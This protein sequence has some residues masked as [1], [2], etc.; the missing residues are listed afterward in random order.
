MVEA[1]TLDQPVGP[2]RDE[3]PDEERARLARQR[4]AARRTTLILVAI[5]LALYFGYIL[6][7]V[8]AGLHAR[9]S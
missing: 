9:H 8:L 5:V 2:Q 3:Q 7:A 1:T 4:R 6:Y